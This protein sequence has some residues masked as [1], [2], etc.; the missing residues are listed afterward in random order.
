[1]GEG[2]ETSAPLERTGVVVT[3]PARQA[4]AL[5][6]S[7]EAA[8][9]RVYRFPVLD[10]VPPDDAGVARGLFQDL[11]AFHLAIFISANAVERGLALMNMAGGLP[12][13]LRIGA[14]GRATAAALGA[15]GIRVDL[16]PGARCDSEALLA[17]DALQGPAIA[18]RRVLI[19]RGE[20]GRELLGE[21]LRQR[22]ARVD[23]AEVYRR[24]RPEVAP[25]SLLD[26]LSRGEVDIIVVTS[27]EGLRNLYEM[28][29]EAGSP[30]LFHI[31]L[32]VVSERVAG[33]ARTMGWR[34]APRVA[35]GAGDEAILEAL[36][37]WRAQLARPCRGMP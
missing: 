33:L 29:G 27:G 6:R 18:G 2:R 25:E 13:G 9:A 36:I 31:P 30:W 11:R 5:V 12:G 8:G 16:V 17:M 24:A 37:R 35:P 20:G 7:L 21:T 4:E 3:R 28:V 14:V 19:V 22:G 15:R 34:T 23:Y 1:M 10:I 32:L 26:P